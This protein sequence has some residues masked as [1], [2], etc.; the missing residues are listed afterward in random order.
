MNTLRACL[1]LPDGA[2]GV[3][4]AHVPLGDLQHGGKFQRGQ[5]TQL[6]RLVV[7]RRKNRRCTPYCS[8]LL[9]HMPHTGSSLR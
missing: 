7:N 9:R 8:E 3:V 6:G 2:S 5:I 1:R 4:A